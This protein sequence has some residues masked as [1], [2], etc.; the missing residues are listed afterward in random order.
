M[1]DDYH[2]NG[3]GIDP[4]ASGAVDRQWSESVNDALAVLR[5]LREPDSDMAA[6]G[7]VDIWE[8]MIV[9]AIG[10]WNFPT[11]KEAGRKAM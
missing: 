10:H 1:S 6:V 8:R 11:S 3:D 9:A 4:H 5:T 7:D 2:A